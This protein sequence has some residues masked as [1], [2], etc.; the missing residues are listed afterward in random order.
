MLYKKVDKIKEEI[1]VIGVG[2]WNF[3]GDWD[4]MSD[5]KSMEIVDKAIE[6]GIN[7]FDVAPVYGFTHAEK[8]LGEALKRNGKRKDVLIASKGGLL[9]DENHVTRNDLS[10]ESLLWEIDQSLERLQ[11]DYVDIYQLHWPDPNTPLK[12]TAEALQIMLD[13]E[14]IRYVGLSNF[15]RAQVDEM[16]T[17]VDVACQQSLYNMFERNTSTYHGI[18]LE[19]RSEDQVLVDV[20]KHGQAFLP[21]S[22]LFQGL[23]TG[24]FKQGHNFSKDDIR[25]E[26]PKLVGPEL[27]RYLDIVEELRVISNEINRPLNEIAF[28]WLRQ[29]PAVTSIIA[30]VSSIEQLEGNVNCL[31]WEIDDETM[32][33]INQIIEPVRY[34]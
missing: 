10:K 26:N 21:Y 29:K 24:K 9:W 33:R 30:G 18:D 6:M 5:E 34:I 23:L 17:Y 32:E 13:A 7:L 3:G 14:K 1:S 19:Y 25:N 27:V 4:N 15:S 12:E 16:M 28:N 11:T 22:P 2:C 20:E 8:I 31:S